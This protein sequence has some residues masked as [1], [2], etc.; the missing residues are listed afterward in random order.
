MDFR[1]RSRLRAAA[2]GL[3]RLWRPATGTGPATPDAV[4]AAADTAPAAAVE[5]DARGGAWHGGTYRHAEGTRHFR[6]YVPPRSATP[7]PL[8]VMLHGCTQDAD[9]FATGT[10]MHEAGPPAFVLYPTQAKNSNALRCWN[11]FMPAHQQA[12]RGEPA[13]LA[14]LTREVASRHPVDPSRIYVAGLSAGG[15][16]AEIL[17]ATHGDL[18][19]A[20][21]IHSG[22][23]LGAAHDVSS[24]LAAMSQGPLAG[25][26]GRALSHPKPLPTFIVHGDADATVH[27]HNGEELVAG[28]LEAHAG[29]GRT[30]VRSVE[31]GHSAD[32]RGHTRESFRDGEGR[33]LLEYWRIHGGTHA[34]S[35]GRPPGSHVDPQGPDVSAAML[36]FLLSHARPATVQRTGT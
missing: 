6:L 27:P 28:R 35:G 12:G 2:R 4:P 21:G 9:D 10:R 20:V 17:A 26:A 5:R 29:A 19:A 18:Y 1:L 3:G 33:V 15:A 11:W 13:L 8:V 36:R 16:M 31:H 32:G 14:A 34:W 24:A 25:G 22:L 23:P 30:L 7:L